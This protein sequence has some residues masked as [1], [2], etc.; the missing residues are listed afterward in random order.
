MDEL[1]VGG[2]VRELRKRRNMSLR[3]LARQSGVALSFLSSLERG[4]N[5]VSVGTLKSILDALG[6]SLGEFFGG[7]A[8]PPAKVVYR[9][10]EHAEISGAKQGL[11][12]LD[13]A[14][15]RRGR[16][17]QLIL[18]NYA[19]GGDTGPEPYRHEAEEAGLVLK[20]KLELTVDNERWELGPGD[21]YYFDSRRPH[22]VRNIGKGPAQA[23]SV[24]TPPSF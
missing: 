19:P 16:A 10:A 14:A 4:G 15:G 7:D 17:L 13:V 20:G 1:R 9:Q 24:N 18:E 12:F 2:R 21:A 5:S 6:T 3:G 22:R 11:Q 23:V 8:P